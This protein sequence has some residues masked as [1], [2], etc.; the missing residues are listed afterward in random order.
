[1]QA[2]KELRLRLSGCLLKYG[3]DPNARFT[4]SWG[5]EA[6]TEHLVRTQGSHKQ[7]CFHHCA[8]FDSAEMIRLF[9]KHRASPYELD[10]MGISVLD[11]AAF[12]ADE[13]VTEAFLDAGYSIREFPQLALENPDEIETFGLSRSLILPAKAAMI[14]DSESARK[15]QARGMEAELSSNR[16]ERHVRED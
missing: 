1:M 5:S 12:R 3:A 15:K 7:T 6:Y 9:L 4:T 10:D 13:K 16:F 2:S 14:W 11:Y 8:R